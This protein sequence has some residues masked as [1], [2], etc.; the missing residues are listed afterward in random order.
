MTLLQEGCCFVLPVQLIVLVLMICNTSCVSLDRTHSRTPSVVGPE[1]RRQQLGS[2]TS[3]YSNSTV[4]MRGV[5]EK[6]ASRMSPHSNP[7]TDDWERERTNVSNSSGES[8]AVEDELQQDEQYS[9][10]SPSFIQVAE[11]VQVYVGAA[12][13]GGPKFSATV[14]CVMCSYILQQIDRKVK[15]LP[16]WSQGGGFFPGTSNFAPGTQRGYYRNYAETTAM[17]ELSAEEKHQQQQQHR[18]MGSLRGGGTSGAG[19]ASVRGVAIP[20]RS[21][22][23]LGAGVVPGTGQRVGD[24]S[25]GARGTGISGPQPVAGATLSTV[26]SGKPVPL[27]PV[28]ERVMK[29]LAIKKNPK[30]SSPAAVKAADEVLRKIFLGT[31]VGPGDDTPEQA[32][33]QNMAEA[34]ASKQYA[35]MIKNSQL[36]RRHRALSSAYADIDRLDN[37]HEA[38]S[39]YTQMFQDFMDALDDIQAHDLPPDYK[40]YAKQI[41]SNAEAAVEYYLHDYE[42]WQICSAI[43]A[44]KPDFYASEAAAVALPL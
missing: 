15:E 36:R 3:S 32:P 21:L 40:Q 28:E 39:E 29:A 42:D 24:G 13:G 12:A 4:A 6:L 43:Y 37:T 44:C 8:A 23:K 26:G 38:S 33:R 30:Q 1:G 22:F 34:G 18:E 25:F 5:V 7:P 16:R 31:G 27:D 35:E 17:L 14:Q 10:S 19:A 11:G 9:D 41:Y 20:T 2:S